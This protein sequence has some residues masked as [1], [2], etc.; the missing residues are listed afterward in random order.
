MYRRLMILLALGAAVVASDAPAEHALVRALR[1]LPPLPALAPTPQTAIAT[2]HEIAPGLAV[3]PDRQVALSGRILFAQGPID[4]LEVVACLAG[5]KNHESLVAL[6]SDQAVLIKATLIA[7]LDLPAFTDGVVEEA[8]LLPPRGV[9]LRVRLRW[10]PD[11]LLDP[12]LVLEADLST[13]IRNR[14]IDRGYPPLPYVYTGSRIQDLPVS[15]PGDTSETTRYAERF[16]LAATRSLVVNFNEPDCLLAA[17]FATAAWDDVF[18]VNTA[19]PVPGVDVS[20]QL[21][22]SRAVLPGTLRAD[23]EALYDETGQL[24]DEAALAAWLTTL[25]LAPGDLHAIA[26]TVAPQLPRQRDAAVRARLLAAAAKVGRWLMPVF[27][28]GE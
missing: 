3:L 22:I 9:P 8:S 28:P 21:L 27:V 25:E 26:I 10:Q 15:V 12:Q 23:A 5:G 13:L 19:Q 2:G 14:L 16:M 1:A 7:T 11:P 6:D 20:V 18:E 24:L 17:P 4:G